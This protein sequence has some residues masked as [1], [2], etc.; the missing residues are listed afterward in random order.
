MRQPPST[1]EKAFKLACDVEKQLQVANSFKLEFSRYPTVEV[2]GMSDEE[3]SGDE[4]E[5][6][7]VS[8]GYKWGN[9]NNYNQKHSNFSNSHNYGK[10]PQQNKP[11]DNWQGKQWGQKSK[12]SKITSTQELAH[13]MPTEFSSSFFKQFDLAMKL[14]QEELRKQ[15]RNSTQVNEITEGDLIQAFGVTEDQM[16]KA[17]AML[18]KSEKTKKLGN[19]LAWLPKD[20]GS[21]NTGDSAEEKEVF[22]INMGNTKV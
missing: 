13:Y 12:D 1:V 21:E 8:R 15:E 4:L 22:F 14:Q 2:N 5:V 9:N 10:R 17:A 18:G 3:S 16:E 7:K 6:N 11:Q 19:S 20:Y